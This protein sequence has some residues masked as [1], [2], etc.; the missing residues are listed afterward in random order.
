MRANACWRRPPGLV[1]RIQPIL[2]A[3]LSACSLSMAHAP[4]AE[5]A[6]CV[7]QAPSY[8]DVASA[9]LLQQATQDASRGENDSALGLSAR[10]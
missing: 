3:C 10:V 7:G 5:S 6:W 2:A 1:L 9:A 8:A 4:I